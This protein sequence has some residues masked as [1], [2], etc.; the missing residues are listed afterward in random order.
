MHFAVKR[1]RAIG[2]QSQESIKRAM[3]RNISTTSP[4]QPSESSQGP[5]KS[6]QEILEFLDSLNEDSK[7]TL[8]QLV[9]EDRLRIALKAGQLCKRLSFPKL[10]LKFL[11]PHFNVWRF[12]QVKGAFEE[13]DTNKDGYLD[14]NE[15][16]K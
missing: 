5:N 8:G 1:T 14:R 16:E 11:C 15:I 10:T 4:L 2:I 9:V 3:L 13:I 12:S 7:H 6:K